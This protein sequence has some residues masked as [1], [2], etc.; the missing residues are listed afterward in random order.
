MR[1][2]VT[3]AVN[4]CCHDG[5]RPRCVRQGP[6]FV[7]EPGGTRTPN[8]LIRRYRICCAELSG[9]RNAGVVAATVDMCGSRWQRFMDKFMDGPSTV[10]ST[11]SDSAAPRCADA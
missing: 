3:F 4:R 2:P 9:A 7:G 11:C 1:R 10:D 6:G 8:L 5:S